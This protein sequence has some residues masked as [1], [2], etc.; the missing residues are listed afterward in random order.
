MNEH[1][2]LVMKWINDPESVSQEERLDAASYDAN[3]CWSASADYNAFYFAAYYAATS[4]P[5]KAAYWVDEYFKETREDKQEYLNK[6]KGEENMSEWKDGIPPVGSEVVMPDCDGYLY[7]NAANESFAIASDEVLIVI[8]VGRRHNDNLPVVTVMAKGH[9]LPGY[10]TVNPHYLTPAKTQ[11]QKDREAFIEK[12]E[13]LAA[14]GEVF[15]PRDIAG[16]MF[17]SGFTA[18][19]GG[20]NE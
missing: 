3:N 16:M 5:E 6:I 18:P 4:E 8:A 13:R 1:I 19:E 17:D 9:G 10:A 7:S 20:S 11:K 14:D 12:V 2:L 15:I